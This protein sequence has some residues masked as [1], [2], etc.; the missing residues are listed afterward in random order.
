MDLNLLTTLDVLLEERS[1]T[2]AAGRL[3][4]SVPATSRALARCRTAFDDPLLVRAGRRYVLTPRAMELRPR[5][6]VL[7][8]EAAALAAPAG[9]FDP[10]TVERT[11][12]IRSG[13]GFHVAHGDDLVR[14]MRA[15]APR[16]GLRLLP[17]GDESPA[18]L[19]TGEVD[20]DVGAA[21]RTPGDVL[22]A[23][24]GVERF[25]G[26]VSVDHPLASQRVTAR[27]FAAAEHVMPSRRGRAHGPIDDALAEHGLS[28]NVLVTASTMTS[29]LQIAATSGLVASVVEP[30]ARAMQDAL[31]LHVFD[32]PVAVEPV[33]LSIA[34]HA[35]QDRDAAH[36]WLRGLV[37]ATMLR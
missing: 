6:R 25:V 28:R 17:E 21:T 1:V 9:A 5:V 7:L 34:W 20:L 23:S 26:A 16:A 31:G 2:G 37:R 35:S 18:A 3:H 29:A 14:R 32:L 15:E 30:V 33:A 36:V 13:D 8:K 10:G 27:R 22:A 11:F 12:A 4:L 24:V 19:R